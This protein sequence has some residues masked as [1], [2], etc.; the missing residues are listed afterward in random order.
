[1]SES[2]IESAR[3]RATIV[4]RVAAVAAGAAFVA[5]LIAA[6][7]NVPSHAHGKPKPLAVPNGFRQAL[8]GAGISGGQVAPAQAPPSGA[9][10]LS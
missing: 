5:T 6:R 9:T 10:G 4:K 8:A 7:S 2:R 1:M 3:S